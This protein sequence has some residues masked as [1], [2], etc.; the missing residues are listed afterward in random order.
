M[1]EVDELRPDTAQETTVDVRVVVERSEL[2]LRVELV[3]RP[4]V[5]HARPHDLTPGDN[6]AYLRFQVHEPSRFMKG[7]QPGTKA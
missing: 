6:L 5:G 2:K 3:L 4:H 1:R 7:P